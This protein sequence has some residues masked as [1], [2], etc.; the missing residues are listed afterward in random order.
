MVVDLDF[1]GVHA[2]EQIFLLFTQG[3]AAV[4]RTELERRIRLGHKAGHADGHL[5]A[6]ALRPVG[7]FVEQIHHLL[8]GVGNNALDVL[9][10][11]SRQAHHK[12]ELDRGVP[13]REGDTAAA[14]NLLPM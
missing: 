6:L 13:F 8:G 7:N 10:R 11:L 2:A 4:L 14:L 12:I 9:Q 1:A 5:Y 3:L